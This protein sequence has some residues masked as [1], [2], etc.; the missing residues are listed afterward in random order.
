M[1][2]RIAIDDWHTSFLRKPR[3]WFRISK[4]YY[5]EYTCTVV[6]HMFCA[7]VYLTPQVDLKNDD[8][9]RALVMLMASYFLNKLNCTRNIFETYSEDINLQEFCSFMSF[10]KLTFRFLNLHLSPMREIESH[11]KTTERVTNRLA[12]SC[13]LMDSWFCNSPIVPFI[14]FR[15]SQLCSCWASNCAWKLQQIQS[16]KCRR[17][18]ILP[19]CI[20]FF[21]YFSAFW[22]SNVWF[23]FDGFCDN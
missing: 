3:D 21:T 1:K 23:G 8:I 16:T 14:C 18:S 5:N 22:R 20:H 6:W 15:D 7:N 13:W 2:N 10:Y 17:F 4:L 12:P 19:N 9:K 11:V